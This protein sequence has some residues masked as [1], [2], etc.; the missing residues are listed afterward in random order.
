M[1]ISN[2]TN[3]NTDT[4]T[5]TQQNYSSSDEASVCFWESNERMWVFRP[6]PI[7]D[8]HIDCNISKGDLPTLAWLERFHPM[9]SDILERAWE[10]AATHNNL[11]RIQLLSLFET[12]S[13]VIDNARKLASLHHNPR[14]L[15]YIDNLK[16]S[17]YRPLPVYGP[18]QLSRKRIKQD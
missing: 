14:I 13:S 1:C 12:P 15:E 16:D 8:M 10:R 5:K 9:W 3:M 6:I 7:G 18:E 11:N 2:C 4:W 17:D